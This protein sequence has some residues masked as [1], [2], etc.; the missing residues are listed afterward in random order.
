MNNL[1]TT[2]RLWLMEA[3]SYLQLAALPA[4]A[5]PPT[6]KPVPEHPG[7][8][9]DGGLAT[10]PIHGPIFRR[11]PEATRAVLNMFG[12]EHTEAQKAAKVLKTLQ[13]ALIISMSIIEITAHHICASRYVTC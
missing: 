12:I 1:F 7:F 3:E 8:T 4:P 9:L 5:T 6:G 11:L 13:E 10:V 2:E